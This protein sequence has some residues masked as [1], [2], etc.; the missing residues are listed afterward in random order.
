MNTCRECSNKQRAPQYS[1]I[2]MLAEVGTFQAT[3]PRDMIYALLSIVSDGPSLVKL[4]SYAPS[5]SKDKIEARIAR[6]LIDKGE[7]IDVLLQA[8]LRQED[9]MTWSS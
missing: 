1:L 6:D 4:V 2:E 7:G 8:G 5:D 9:E 3:D